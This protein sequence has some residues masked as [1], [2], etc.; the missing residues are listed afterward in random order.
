MTDIIGTNRTSK[1]CQSEQ[2]RSRRCF[3]QQSGYSNCEQKGIIK[4]YQIRAPFI[5]DA[6]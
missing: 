5:I 4:D 3:S 2:G 6:T 1:N